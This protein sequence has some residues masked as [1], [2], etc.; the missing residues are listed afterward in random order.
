MFNLQKLWRSFV[1]LVT[2]REPS[3]DAVDSVL[4]QGSEVDLGL[5]LGAKGRLNSPC[6]H[7]VVLDMNP[8]QLNETM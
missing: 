5:P 4:Y 3:G 2:Q 6:E 8:G 1:I 7:S